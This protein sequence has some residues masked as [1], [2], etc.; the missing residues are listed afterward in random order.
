MVH[1]Y[2]QQSIPD[3]KSG[4]ADSLDDTSL[5]DNPILNALLTDTIFASGRR[6]SSLSPAMGPLAGVPDQSRRTTM[7]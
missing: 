3:G 5:L 4:I 1:R 7:L 2:P 6:C